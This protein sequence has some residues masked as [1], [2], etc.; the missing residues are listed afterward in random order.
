MDVQQVAKQLREQLE[1]LAT[2]NPLLVPVVGSIAGLLF[3]IALLYS[4]G[5]SSTKKKLT[6]TVFEGGVRRST[7]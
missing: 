7:R 6:G 3:V 1:A 5:A 2:S 4:C